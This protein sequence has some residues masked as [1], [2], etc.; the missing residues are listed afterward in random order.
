MIKNS[1]KNLSE[2]VVGRGLLIVAYGVA[3]LP[4]EGL[5]AMEDALNLQMQTQVTTSFDL[6]LQNYFFSSEAATKSAKA[7]IDLFDVVLE[8]LSQVWLQYPSAIQKSLDSADYSIFDFI[9][10]NMSP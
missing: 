6:V 1:V 4:K 7:K 10:R 5:Q 8:G 2:R 3:S 9:M